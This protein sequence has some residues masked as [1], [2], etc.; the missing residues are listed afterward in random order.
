MEQYPWNRLVNYNSRP[1]ET[2]K[3]WEE[4][5]ENINDMLIKEKHFK[6]LKNIKNIIE[7]VSDLCINEAYIK[8]RNTYNRQQDS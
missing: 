2:P 1:L 6:I 5:A 4:L 3:K 7:D 8:E